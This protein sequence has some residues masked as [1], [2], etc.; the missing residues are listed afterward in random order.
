MATLV[1]Q[2]VGAAVG[3]AVGGPFGAALGRAVG[4]LTGAAIDLSLIGGD[5]RQVEGPRLAM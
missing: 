5:A 1:L 3:G 2:T 4:G